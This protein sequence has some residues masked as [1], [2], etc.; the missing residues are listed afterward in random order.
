MSIKRFE[1]CGIIESDSYIS[2]SLQTST[3][4]RASTG[5]Q[6]TFSALWH[7]SHLPF[8]ATASKTIVLLQCTLCQEAEDE[9]SNMLSMLLENDITLHML[10]PHA[11][12]FHAGQGKASKVYGVDLNGA[13]S[14]RNLRN[15]MPSF[16]LLRQVMCH[17]RTCNHYFL[18]QWCKLVV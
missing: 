8:R 6:R 11:L 18:Y 1:K 14:G 16:T 17:H 9:Y 5:N 10:Q 3:P 2:L 12:K 4:K 7:A 15:L 13:F